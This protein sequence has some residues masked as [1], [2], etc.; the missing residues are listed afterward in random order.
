M[1]WY[2]KIKLIRKKLNLTQIGLAEALGIKQST[3]SQYEKGNSYPEGN[4][5]KKILELAKQAKVF[6]K[7]EELL[8]D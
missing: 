5:R 4:N 6:L 1:H 8:R 2:E 3:V 7:L